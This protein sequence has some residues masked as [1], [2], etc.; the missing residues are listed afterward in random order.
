M[1]FRTDNTKMQNA[2]QESPIICQPVEPFADKF[3][4]ELSG[5]IWLRPISRPEKT[6]KN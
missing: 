1:H 3:G 4:Q 6:P 5:C 2:G